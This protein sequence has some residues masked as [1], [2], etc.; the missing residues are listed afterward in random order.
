MNATPEIL[1]AA[2]ALYDVCPTPK[3]SWDQLGDATRAFWIE[4]ALKEAQHT[5]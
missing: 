4:R 1:A 5:C 3:P 2:R